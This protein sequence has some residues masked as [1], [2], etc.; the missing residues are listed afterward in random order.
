M[1]HSATA[2]A[3]LVW[4]ILSA[5]TAASWT[6]GNT[7]VAFADTSALA[8]DT[9]L[10]LLLALVKVRLVLMHFM[11]VRHAPSGLRLLCEAWLAGLGC[12]LIGLHLRSLGLI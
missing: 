6:L 2:R 4:I 10:I 3:T 1:F 7:S 5:A 9:S 11:E 12:L 8:W